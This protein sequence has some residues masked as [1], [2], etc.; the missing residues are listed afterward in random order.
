MTSASTTPNDVNEQIDR[1]LDQLDEQTIEHLNEPHP[2]NDNCNDRSS[3][4]QAS[5]PIVRHLSV[6][7]TETRRNSSKPNQILQ[8]TEE[9][10]SEMASRLANITF[11][12]NFALLLA[13]VIA[14]ALSG[15]ISIISSMVDSL[16]D[17]TSGFVIS[18]SSKLIKERDP[19][20]YPRGRAQLEPIS[21]ILISVIMGLTS[22]QL[23]I[24]SAYR[25]HEAFLY[26]FYG[27]GEEPTLDMGWPTVLIMISTICIKFGLFLIC[28]KNT[29]DSSIAV[30]AMDHRNDCISNSIAL[31]CAWLANKFYY[32]LDPIGAIFVSFYILHTWV[33]TGKEHILQL[34]GKS[35]DPEFIN[36]IIKVCIDHDERI[37]KLDTVYVYHYGT[38]FLVEVH[39]VLNE[40]MPLRIAH[41][42]SEDLQINIESLPDVERA[43]VHIDYEF[44]HKPQDEH[45]VS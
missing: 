31:V 26:D 38:K 40:E 22:I 32:Y 7:D 17:L 30:L 25:I 19:Y 43:F 5:P 9:N 18:V 8:M 20:L 16:V 39:I 1:Q 2:P 11:F 42:I 14:S 34:S 4:Q 23:I 45:I 33:Q 28:Q 6:F 21:L 13:K 41:D 37:E 27:K 24:Q 3:H 36:R 15:S 12:V 29:S 44:E 35:A 10:E